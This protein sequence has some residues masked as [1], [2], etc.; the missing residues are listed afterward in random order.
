MEKLKEE[1]DEMLPQQGSVKLPARGKDYVVLPTSDKV[2]FKL[3]CLPH[4]A[5]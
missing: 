3:E 2:N 1:D 5:L 4:V